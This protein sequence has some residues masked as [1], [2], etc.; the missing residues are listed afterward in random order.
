MSDLAPRG[1]GKSELQIS[2][3]AC[4]CCYSFCCLKKPSIF[5]L[6]CQDPENRL[7]NSSR[8]P[9]KKCT[10]CRALCNKA[11]LKFHAVLHRVR[12]EYILKLCF[13]QCRVSQCRVKHDHDHGHSNYNVVV[14][15]E[16]LRRHSLYPNIR[17][18]SSVL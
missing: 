6:R 5:C 2:R 17:R 10:N 1:S 7:V 3:G 13:P 11:F 18:P 9:L 14:T 8:K 12:C 15:L 16:E 4:C